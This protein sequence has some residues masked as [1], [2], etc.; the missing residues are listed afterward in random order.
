MRMS[1]NWSLLRHGRVGNDRSEGTRSGVCYHETAL[2]YHLAPKITLMS[3]SDSQQH[4]LCLSF[5]LNSH[6]VV[7]SFG[8]FLIVV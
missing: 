4:L 2:L 1:R 6:P 7:P 8:Y 3:C 5:H